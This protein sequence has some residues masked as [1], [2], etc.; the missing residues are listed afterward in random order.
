MGESWL[1]LL[2]K[3]KLQTRSGQILGEEAG[4]AR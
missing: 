2:N 4:G 3:T 1:Q